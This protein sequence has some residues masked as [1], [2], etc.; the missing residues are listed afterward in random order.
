MGFPLCICLPLLHLLVFLV[1]Q[2]YWIMVHFNYHSDPFPN[3]V[4]FWGIEVR[5]SAYERRSPF[6]PY[7]ML[8]EGLVNDTISYLR[9]GWTT[10]KQAREWAPGPGILFTGNMTL[11]GFLIL[12]RCLISLNQMRTEKINH[13]ISVL[14]YKVTVSICQG[15][16]VIEERQEQP[17]TELILVSEETA[18]PLKHL[19]STPK[20]FKCTSTTLQF[21][22]PTAANRVCSDVSAYEDWQHGIL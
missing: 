16:I 9:N 15:Q 7:W 2:S 19:E 1:Y 6:S 8:S 14:R 22:H 12:S 13:R 11:I 4:T 3:T 20:L 18:P 21:K 10:G 17:S 5:T